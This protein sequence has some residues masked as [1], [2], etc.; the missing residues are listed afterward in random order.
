MLVIKPGKWINCANS[1]FIYRRFM[2]KGYIR[3]PF[4]FRHR[5]WPARCKNCPKL[6]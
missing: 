2:L 4:C 3:T 5:R 1:D 6:R